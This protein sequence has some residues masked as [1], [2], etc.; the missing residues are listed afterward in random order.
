MSDA[1]LE[2]KV[3]RTRSERGAALMFVL[4]GLSLLTVLGL[5]LTGLG[6]VSLANSKSERE[7]VEVL[8][9]ADA[10]ISHA[11]K[12]IIWQE[13]GSFDQFLQSGNGTACDGDE[14]AQAP[15]AGPP[16][17]YAPLPAGYPT[18]AADFIPATGQPYGGQGRQYRVA[19]CDDH[20]TDIDP[21]TGILNTNANADVNKRIRVRSTGTGANGA[22]ATIEIVI[23]AMDVPAVI[24][25]G[26]LEIRGNP[27]ALGVGGAFHANGQLELSGNPCAAQYFSST[28]DL[29]QGSNAEGGTTCTAADADTRP[30]TD[31]IN[32][33]LLNPSSFID[34]AD[35]W[36]TASGT[37]KQKVGGS[38]VTVSPIPTSGA[39]A[40]LSNWSPQFGGQQAEWRAMGDVTPGTYYVEGNTVIAGNLGAGTPIAMT[41]IT[42]GFYK[43]TGNP[44]TTPALTLP[45]RGPIA[46]IAGTDILLSAAFNNPSSGLYYAHDQLD[47]AG[48]PTINGQIVAANLQDVFYP[49]TTGQVNNIVQ[50]NGGQMELTGNPTITFG[51][52]GLVAARMTA[53]R[54][55]R[56]GDPANPCGTP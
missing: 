15:I 31:P 52:N 48:S 6:M 13:W 38:W 10:G 35:F 40:L 23:S 34:N 29:V 19:V 39:L 47:I 7:T 14:L 12:L 30:N 55:C 33:P 26:N 50:L 11:K 22:S 9:I 56:G 28:G 3:M 4:F 16:S 46:V 51:G 24:V 42:E 2:G 8:G 20:A 44:I 18:L 1:D 49:S 43:V 21:L 41:I 5:G 45:F 37:I 36:L 32:V 54:E 17:S 25:N 27:T 53:W